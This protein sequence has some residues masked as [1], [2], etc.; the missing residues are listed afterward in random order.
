MLPPTEIMA[1]WYM[2][3]PGL[4]LDMVGITTT[5]KIDWKSQIEQLGYRYWQIPLDIKLN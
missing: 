5:N 3:L 2:L 4:M 1:R